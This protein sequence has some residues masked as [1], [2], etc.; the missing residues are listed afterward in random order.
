M[1]KVKMSLPNKKNIDLPKEDGEFLAPQP[2]IKP[3]TKQK[4]EKTAI[5]DKITPL[6]EADK[7]DPENEKPSEVEKISNNNENNPESLASIKSKSLSKGPTQA[8]VEKSIPIPYK[9]RVFF[10]YLCN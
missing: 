1:L 4:N 7:V 3:K 9:V 2:F 10:S 6:K 8:L 5:A